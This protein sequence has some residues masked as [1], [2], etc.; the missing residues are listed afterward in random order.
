MISA[1]SKQ[2]FRIFDCAE[3]F[4]FKTLL[5]FLGLV[6]LYS[7]PPKYHICYLC[8]QS[9][10]YLFSWCKKPSAM[11]TLFDLLT[12]QL[13]TNNTHVLASSSLAAMHLK[14]LQMHTLVQRISV[15]T[16]REGREALL[17]FFRETLIQG[18]RCKVMIQ[19]MV[20]YTVLQKYAHIGLK[21]NL[22][23]STTLDISRELKRTDAA[24]ER[25]GQQ[26]NFY[27]EGPKAN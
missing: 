26:A 6:G 19:I 20:F 22:L 17:F 27:S 5:Y 18:S 10:D 4:L 12:E 8:L 14:T 9:K 24:A 25:S 3:Y 7:L 1:F 23:R 15:R 21:Q 2:V 13:S 11:P 16:V